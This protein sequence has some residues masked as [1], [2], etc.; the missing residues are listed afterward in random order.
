M[1]RE[2][3]PFC[4]YCGAKIKWA[5]FNNETSLLTFHCQCGEVVYVEIKLEDVEGLLPNPR[6]AQGC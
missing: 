5:F 2:D 6:S 4:L 3:Y 1:G